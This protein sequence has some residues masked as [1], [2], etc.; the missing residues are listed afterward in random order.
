MPAIIGAQKP[1]GHPEM[2]QNR[3][4][5]EVAIMA[6]NADREREAAIHVQ[7]RCR[8]LWLAGLG[9][10]HGTGQADI[11]L[12]AKVEAVFT[13]V[14]EPVKFRRKIGEQHVFPMGIGTDDRSGVIDT[15]S[16]TNG[17]AR[18]VF[19]SDC[20]PVGN[21]VHQFLP[22][23]REHPGIAVSK[24]AQPVFNRREDGNQCR[25][26]VLR[27]TDYVAVQRKFEVSNGKW[28]DIMRSS[29]MIC[30]SLFRSTGLSGSIVDSVRTLRTHCCAS[31]KA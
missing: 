12:A 5:R 20:R 19:D 1:I 22:F 4:D 15:F 21:V 26:P 3:H 27:G 17:V 13:N 10:R 23:T 31:F 24:D 29:V 16:Q 14:H 6:A 11:D 8:N 7:A 2:T 25:E 18:F 30:A 9:W 28:V